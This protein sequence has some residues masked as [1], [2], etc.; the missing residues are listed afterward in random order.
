MKIRTVRF[1][2]SEVEVVDF[3]DV[4]VAERVIEF[5]CRNDPKIS[6]FAAVVIPDGGDWSAALLGVDPRVGDISAALMARLIE[7][8]RELI[9]VR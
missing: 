7:V 4:T 6:S 1:G 2:D 3:E 9:E 5:R 8:A